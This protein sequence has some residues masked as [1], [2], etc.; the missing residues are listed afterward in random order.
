MSEP[1]VSMRSLMRSLSARLKSSALR[2]LLDDVSE[3]KHRTRDQRE[4]TTCRLSYQRV[5]EG[6]AIRSRC[7]KVN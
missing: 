3:C 6:Y 4:A 5:L 2:T 1:R 7:G